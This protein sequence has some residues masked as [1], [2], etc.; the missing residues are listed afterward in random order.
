M[1]LIF[2]SS[3]LKYYLTVTVGWILARA[4]GLAKEGNWTTTN[5]AFDVLSLQALF[6]VPTL[7]KHA[8]VRSLV[9]SLSWDSGNIMDNSYQR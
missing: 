7:L 4:I 3:T 1:V 2:G 5:F 8:D 9:H 6:L